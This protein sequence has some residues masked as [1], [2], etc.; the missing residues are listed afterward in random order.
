MLRLAGHCPSVAA[1][2]PEQCQLAANIPGVRFS[3][4]QHS[5]NSQSVLNAS[6]EEDYKAV[7]K[8]GQQSGDSGRVVVSEDEVVT[9]CEQQCQGPW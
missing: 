8:A 5:T 1:Q 3:R 2:Y 9:H 7:M 4:L 6:F